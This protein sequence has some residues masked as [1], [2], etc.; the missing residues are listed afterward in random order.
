VSE[1]LDVPELEVPVLLLPSMFSS[2]LPAL[3]PVLVPL[4]PELE[5][6]ELSLFIASNMAMLACILATATSML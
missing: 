3:V 6:D 4:L 2:E 1:L 5:L